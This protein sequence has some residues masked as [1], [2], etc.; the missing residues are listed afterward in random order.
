M[1]NDEIL[2]LIKFMCKRARR[3]NH[4]YKEAGKVYKTVAPGRISTQMWAYGFL[5]NEAIMY[6][7][8]I[9]GIYRRYGG[10]R[11]NNGLSNL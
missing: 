9:N 4:D 11:G 8:E 10:K 2:E 1:I 6:I 7:T 5:H 3:H